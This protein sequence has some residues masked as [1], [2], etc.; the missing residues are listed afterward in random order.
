MKTMEPEDDG[1]RLM[2]LG[3][4]EYYYGDYQ[5]GSAANHHDEG[6]L[7]KIGEGN[8]AAILFGA[9]WAVVGAYY[10]RSGA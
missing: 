4:D 10:Y 7:A 1:V 2:C 5:A 8:T 9:L 3:D 6:A